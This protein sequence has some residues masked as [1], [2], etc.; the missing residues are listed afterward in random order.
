MNRE[1]KRAQIAARRKLRQA[2]AKQAREAV[3]RAPD[4]L[5]S[6]AGIA[7]AAVHALRNQ[8]RLRNP[9]VSEATLGGLVAEACVKASEKLTAGEV[10][11]F[12]F[13]SAW[14]ETVFALGTELDEDAGVFERAWPRDQW[15]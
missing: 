12:E 15:E 2:A 6:L 14:Y 1:Q 9:D 4:G 5:H 3:H 7:D 10:P 13:V 8:L 11:P